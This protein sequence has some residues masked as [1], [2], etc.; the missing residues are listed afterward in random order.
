MQGAGGSSLP[1]LQEVALHP[2]EGATRPAHA[3][4]PLP[5]GVLY[6]MCDDLPAVMKRLAER[7]VRCTETAAAPWGSK[8]TTRL[9][10]G[11][12]IG[13]YQP[14]HP[15]ALGLTSAS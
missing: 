2:M 3:G 12:E 6:L 1:C 14:R 11:G 15:V 8:T 5:G 13:L 7:Q 10:S 9:P 4:H